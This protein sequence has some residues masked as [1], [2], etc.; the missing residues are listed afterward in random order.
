MHNAIDALTRVTE[1]HAVLTYAVGGLR[2][3]ECL[4]SLEGP[5]NT[6]QRALSGVTALLVMNPDVTVDLK[7][8]PARGGEISAILDE[9]VSIPSEPLK[10]YLVAH[11][12]DERRIADEICAAFNARPVMV[13]PDQFGGF[14][15]DISQ[16]IEQWLDG[17]DPYGEDSYQYPDALVAEEEDEDE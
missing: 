3:G 7:I 14:S 4:S 2:D 13:N 9:L 1:A 15:V 10:A 16:H 6:L 17:T 8:E 12:N 5:L 11:S